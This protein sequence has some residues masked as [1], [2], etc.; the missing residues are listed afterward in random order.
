MQRFDH[1]QAS[2][3]EQAVGVLAAS[4]GGAV[5]IAGGTDLLG[6]LKDR[7]LPGYPKLLVN[8][9]TIPGLD[10]VERDGARVRIGALARLSRLAGAAALEGPLD[11]VA[12]AAAAVATPQLRNVGTVGGNLCQDV[13]CLYYRY[14]DSIGGRLMCRRK[15]SGPCLVVKGDARYSALIPGDGCFAAGPSDLSVALAALDATVRVAGPDGPRELAMD[16][17]YQ[18]SRTALRPAELVTGVDVPFPAAGT[19]S[20]FL[21]FRL[22]DAVD[23]AIV[24]VAASL[25]VVEG[26]CRGARIVLGAVAPTP[27]RATAAETY[28]Q[29]KR[30]TAA[31]AAAA[32][33]L[34]FEKVKPLPSAAYKVKIGKEL[35]RQSLMGG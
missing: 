12:R 25:T 32:A 2:S 24:S 15:G 23:F 11:A 35:V 18:G 29:G 22:R 34:A 6:V 19:T 26:E 5:P 27:V 1:V 21:K 7:I 8:L 3:V 9:K 10:T 14:P 33:D 28:L 30:I 16:A 31:T 4:D 13:R 20:R 17:F